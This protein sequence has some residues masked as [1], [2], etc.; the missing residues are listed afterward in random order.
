MDKVVKEVIKADQLGLIPVEKP[1]VINT[2]I[3]GFEFEIRGVV[4]DNE[5]KF[6]TFFIPKK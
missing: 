5:L 1:F 2:F 6:G 4:L 3:G